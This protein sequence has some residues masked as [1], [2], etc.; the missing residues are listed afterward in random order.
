VG[1]YPAAV[2]G[3]PS[4]PGGPG[5]PGVDVA[6]WPAPLRALVTGEQVLVATTDPLPDG[7]LHLV[8]TGGQRTDLLKPA[9]RRWTDAAGATGVAEVVERWT[10]TTAADVEAALG[11]TVLEAAFATDEL[12]WT[13]GVPL[14]V[15]ALRV[16]PAGP[17]GPTSLSEDML[18]ARRKGLRDALAG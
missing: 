10:L 7:P 6:L 17:D 14:H 11:R 15:A 16:R 2:A 3:D 18:E 13:E 9:Y 4:A 12:A 8:A 1:A 5:A